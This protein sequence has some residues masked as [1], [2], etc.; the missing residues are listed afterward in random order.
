MYA[1]LQV[2]NKV[3]MH[4]DVL[5]SQILSLKL[6]GFVHDVSESRY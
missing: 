2:S 4:N 5:H 1:E 6:T 3:I